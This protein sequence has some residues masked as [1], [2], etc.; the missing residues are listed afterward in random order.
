MFA[1]LSKLFGTARDTAAT[2]TSVEAVKEIVVE[3]VVE[4]VSL[5]VQGKSRTMKKAPA[6]PRRTKTKA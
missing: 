4:P 1:W 2:V 6:R 5:P 3:P